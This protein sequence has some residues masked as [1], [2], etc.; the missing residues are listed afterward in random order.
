MNITVFNEYHPDE[1][2]GKAAKTY[3][4]GIHT[5]LAELFGQ[6]PDVQ[7]RTAT[8]EEPVHGLTD[9]VLDS[10]DVLVWWSK[11]WNNELLESVADKVASRILGGMGAI[12]L[13]SGK[14]SKPFRKLM[15]TTCATN[16]GIRAGESGET[17]KLY[18]CCPSHPIAEGFPNGYVIPNEEPYCEYFDIPEPDD[19]V[20]MGWFDGGSAVRAGVTFRRGAGKIFYFQPGHETFPVYRDEA[21][22]R[23]LLNAARWAA[24]TQLAA[25]A[26]SPVK[27]KTSI[28]ARIFKFLK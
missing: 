20:F 13:H 2:S 26:A 22:K 17:E 4:G 7:V 14:N 3:P 9:E 23:V 24:P 10:T 21:I 15:G 27:A 8:Q 28:K 18:V 1:Q 11:D 6:L 5:T 16:P 25:P 19:I 12:F